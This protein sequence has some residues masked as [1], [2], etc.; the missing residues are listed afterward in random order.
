MKEYS[1]HVWFPNV[2]GD[3]GAPHCANERRIVSKP[4]TP[5]ER[6]QNLRACVEA[7]EPLSITFIFQ[8]SFDVAVGGAFFERF[9]LVE[10]FLAA[11]HGDIEFQ[12][13]AFIIH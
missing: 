9:T 4:V 1:L 13:T 12:F 11:N 7:G 3:F 6:S 8:N 2:L 5:D 10:L